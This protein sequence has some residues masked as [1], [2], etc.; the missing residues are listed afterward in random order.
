MPEQQVHD[1]DDPD[2]SDEDEYGLEFMSNHGDQAQSTPMKYRFRNI[3]FH[4]EHCG[5]EVV[6]VPPIYSIRRRIRWIDV[7]CR[8]ARAMGT[9]ALAPDPGIVT[10]SALTSDRLFSVACRN[11]NHLLHTP[12]ISTGHHSP[13]CLALCPLH[14]ELSRRRGS[15]GGAWI[16]HLLRNRAALVPQI[17]RA[18][19]SKPASYATNT[20]RLLA[21]R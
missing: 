2:Q 8:S 14:F 13:R 11:S 9:P 7:Q 6:R 12:S 5:S 15:I 10:L 4:F 21:S 18:N 1:F 19:R 17:R 16:G 20:Q 3:V